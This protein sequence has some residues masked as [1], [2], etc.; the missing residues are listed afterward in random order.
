MYL[1]SLLVSM[2]RSPRTRPQL[3]QT[4]SPELNSSTRF[5][6]ISRQSASGIRDGC[7]NQGLEVYLTRAHH[8]HVEV[9]APLLFL[10][11]EAGGFIDLA[12]REQAAVWSE[13]HGEQQLGGKGQYAAV[14]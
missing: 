4:V 12:R 5:G 14:T 6:G 8:S 1:H 9:L 3:P 7:D 10:F 13:R 2:A 11:G